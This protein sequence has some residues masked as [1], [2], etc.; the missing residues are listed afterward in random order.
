MSNA[1]W[2]KYTVVCHIY[3]LVWCT[4][5]NSASCCLT[6]QSSASI[7]LKSDVER[8]VLQTYSL[9]HCIEKSASCFLTVMQNS[10]SFVV[11]QRSRPCSASAWCRAVKYTF[12]VWEWCEA[13]LSVVSELRRA[14]PSLVSF[15]QYVGLADALLN[16]K[17]TDA[18]LSVSF[19]VHFLNTWNI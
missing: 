4:M 5:K 13:L 11:E 8:C 7:V 2:A 9:E 19:S 1:F 14:V 12:V 15:W 18:L 17:T 6:V 3:C 10:A 16:W